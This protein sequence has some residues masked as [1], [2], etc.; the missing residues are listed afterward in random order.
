MSG[1]F[2]AQ[3]N[4]S[5][6]SC[7]HCQDVSCGASPMEKFM[8]GLADMMGGQSA[9][10]DTAESLQSL[11]QERGPRDVNEFRRDLIRQAR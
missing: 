3:V 10:E 11:S 5:G 9:D 1:G 6:Y 4:S 7:A 2:L 8:N